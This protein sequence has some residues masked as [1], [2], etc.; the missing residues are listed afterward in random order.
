M[1]DSTVF[2]FDNI[3]ISKRP[4]CF[5]KKTDEKCI[6]RPQ[7]AF[8]LH[9]AESYD[10]SFSANTFQ[11]YSSSSVARAYI[12][13]KSQ[14]IYELGF[15][16]LSQKIW[17]SNHIKPALLQVTESNNKLINMLLQTFIKTSLIPPLSQSPHSFAVTYFRAAFVTL[18]GMSLRA[19]VLYG[20]CTGQEWLF[21][22]APMQVTAGLK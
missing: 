4:N 6:Q 10:I 22:P 12:F 13:R 8:V 18:M 7:A 14:L 21:C 20:A 9:P 19:R 5:L 3:G 2:P 16:L 17:C 11:F 15:F 1:C